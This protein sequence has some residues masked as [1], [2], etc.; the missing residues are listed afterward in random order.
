[1]A[2]LLDKSYRS[3]PTSLGLLSWNTRWGL[4]DHFTTDCFFWGLFPVCFIAPRGNPRAKMH[5]TT[6]SHS[7]LHQSRSTL[8]NHIQSHTAQTIAA[9][10]PDLFQLIPVIHGWVGRR[11]A[12]AERCFESSNPQLMCIIC[13]EQGWNLMW[14]PG[15]FLEY[16]PVVNSLPWN[17]TILSFKG[18][19]ILSISII[20]YNYSI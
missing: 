19:C 12:Q 8:T 1:M 9:N 7:L 18:P 3:Y 13:P 6:C 11:A 20:T 15:N 5:D 10:R 14:N 4:V 17:I 16:H 2:Y